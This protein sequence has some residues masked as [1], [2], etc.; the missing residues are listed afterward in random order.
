MTGPSDLVN[1]YAQKL[2]AGGTFVRTLKAGHIAPH[3]PYIAPLRPKLLDALNTYV[4]YTF[5]S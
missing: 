3:S 4:N 1:A 5:I 2:Q